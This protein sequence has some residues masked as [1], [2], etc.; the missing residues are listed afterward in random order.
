[1]RKKTFED[2]KK[3][4][5]DTFDG[6]SPEKPVAHRPVHIVRTGIDTGPD[7]LRDIKHQMSQS[8]FDEKG[9]IK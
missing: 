5:F 8:S 7:A 9:E 1:L 2:H 3:H 6:R 4:F